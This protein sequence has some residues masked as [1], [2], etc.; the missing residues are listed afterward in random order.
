ML[1]L[2]AVGALAVVVSVVA[3]LSDGG[4]SRGA[5]LQHSPLIGQTAPALSGKTVTGGHASLASYRGRWVIVN[6]FASWCDPCQKETPELVHFAVA[7]RGGNGPAILGVVHL[8]DDESVRGF[9]RAHN[10]TWPLLAYRTIDRADAYGVAQIPTTFLI[11]PDGRVAAKLAG[12]MGPGQ[13][14]SLLAQAQA[15]VR[16]AAQIH[17]AAQ[18]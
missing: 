9:T 17:A 4:G 13:L 11:R 15:Q 14:D 8:D 10:V 6:F 12:A 2:A 1:L 5:V 3:A 16:A 18:G 7:H